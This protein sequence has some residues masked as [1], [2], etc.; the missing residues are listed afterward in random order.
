MRI[1]PPRER[2]QVTGKVIH[3]RYQDAASVVGRIPKAK[4]D[5]AT[6]PRSFYR[7]EHCKHWHTTSYTPEH[8]AGIKRCNKRKKARNQ[9]S[10]RHD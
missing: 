2:C 6:V 3:K 9:R 5:Q 8:T 4:R 10:P 1:S 7:C